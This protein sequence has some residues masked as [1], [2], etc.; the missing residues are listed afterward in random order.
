M[1]KPAVAVAAIVVGLVVL[2][3]TPVGEV[4]SR[5]FQEVLVMNFPETQT[6]R[7]K[8]SVEGLIRSAE[9]AAVEDTTVPPV[10]PA[11]TNRLVDAGT[12]DTDG[13]TYA[14]LSLAG[15]VKG[16][17]GKAGT[18]GALLIPEVETTSRAFNEKGQVLFPLGVEAAAEPGSTGFF[19]SEPSRRMLAFPRYRVFLYNTTDQAVSVDLY[20]YLTNE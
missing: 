14:V 6:V 10:K 11:D 7:G 1:K 16:Q 4:V 8:V 2:I 17:V 3:L 18:I 9:L 19:G 12:L 13:K 20:A 5:E 15:H